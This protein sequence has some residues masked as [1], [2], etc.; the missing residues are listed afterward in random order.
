MTFSVHHPQRPTELIV[1]LTTLQFIAAGLKTE[2]PGNTSFHRALDKAL[3]QLDAGR[4]FTLRGNMLEIQSESRHWVMHTATVESCDCEA[5]QGV[6][7][8]RAA[9]ALLVAYETIHAAALLCEPLA[10]IQRQPRRHRVA[11]ARVQLDRSRIDAIK[12]TMT[13]DEISESL[14]A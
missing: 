5:M 12:R 14:A 1:N 13:P 2:Q 6:C 3:R 11:A 8:H 7:W 10:P 4:A 9:C